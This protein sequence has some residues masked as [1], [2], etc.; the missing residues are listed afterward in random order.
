MLMMQRTVYM[1]LPK[2]LTQQNKSIIYADITKINFNVNTT[3]M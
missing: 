3:L 1:P 2:F